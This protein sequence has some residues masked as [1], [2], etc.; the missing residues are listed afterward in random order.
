MPNSRHDDNRVAISVE[1]AINLPWPVFI[2]LI[3]V[4]VILL[5]LRH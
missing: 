3:T 1:F 2:G 5:E 4:L